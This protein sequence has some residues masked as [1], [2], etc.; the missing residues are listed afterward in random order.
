MV[1]RRPRALVVLVLVAAAMIGPERATANVGSCPYV[2]SWDA[3]T[4]PVDVVRNVREGLLTIRPRLSDERARSS[5]DRTIVALD[6]TLEP[7]RWT[8]AGS[9]RATAAGVAGVVG[10][11]TAAGRLAWSDVGAALATQLEVRALVATM[12]RL[13]RLRL[14]DVVA[15]EADPTAVWRAAYDADRGDAYFAEQP[16]QASYSYL[17]AWGRLAVLP[18]FEPGSPPPTGLPD[19]SVVPGGEEGGGGSS[20][21]SGG[22][23]SGGGGTGTGSGTGSGAS[24]SAAQPARIA[25]TALPAVARAGAP[26]QLRYR[27]LS[28]DA[29]REDVWVRHRGKVVARLS[30]A[31]ARRASGV[32][33]VRLKSIGR[34]GRL[35]FCVRARHRDGVVST[36]SCA[37][38]E[39]RFVVRA[40]ASRGVAGK[41]VRLRY[42]VAT[43]QPTRATI[44]IRDGRRRVG[45]VRASGLSRAALRRVGWRPSRAL[46]GKTL[47]FCVTARTKAGHRSVT[48]CARVQLRR[49]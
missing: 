38:L 1:S 7:E 37:P 26:L 11:R 18:P 48:S 31:F 4:R 10:L 47:S 39:I 29:T 5:V 17:Q 34:T 30:T 9:L 49:P 27:V 35:S 15:A 3:G 32:A 21:G 42:R 33:A 14:A 43:S 23:T 40:L 44:V 20:S 41:V 13:V 36:A 12:S 22:G 25:V 16:L 19:E 28:D 45:T 8:A 6:W 2:C 46:A 24:T